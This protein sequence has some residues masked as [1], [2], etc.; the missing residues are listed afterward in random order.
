MVRI[1][2]DLCDGAD[3][4]RVFFQVYSQKKDLVGKNVGAVEG[5]K[6]MSIKAIKSVA[7]LIRRGKGILG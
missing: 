7:L 4:H 5:I 1:N 6:L 2:G 3:V